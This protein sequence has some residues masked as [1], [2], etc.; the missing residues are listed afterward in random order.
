[1]HNLCCFF[2]HGNCFGKLTLRVNLNPYSLNR[3]RII[4]GLPLKEIIV[5]PLSPT[6]LYPCCLL[7]TFQRR[8]GRETRGHEKA[9]ALQNPWPSQISS[10]RC[11][12]TQ[13]CS[14]FRETTALGSRGWE[15]A[16]R[17]GFDVGYTSEENFRRLSHDAALI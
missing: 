17:G 5:S 4:K 11:G 12:S 15:M 13:C 6:M 16:H 8:D 14:D 7:E 1:V 2:D 10:Y 9:S 3:D